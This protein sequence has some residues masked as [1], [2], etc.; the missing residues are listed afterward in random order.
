[1]AKIGAINAEK[2]TSAPLTVC[3]TYAMIPE[4]WKISAFK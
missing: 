1:M 3:E 2:I 4:R